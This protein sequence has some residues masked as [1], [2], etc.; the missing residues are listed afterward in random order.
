VVA[1]R[2]ATPADADGVTTLLRA[3]YGELLREHYDPAVM[4]NVLPLMT[5]ANPSLLASGTFYVV[6]LEPVGVAGCGGWTM[7]QPGTAELID[8]V[9]HIRHFATHPLA[10]RR[11]IGRT[12]MDRCRRE[13]AAQG[14]RSLQC[15]STLTAESFYAAC[16]FKTLRAMDVMIGGTVA[17]PSVVMERDL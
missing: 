11:G 14:A 1:T 9:A 6:D 4:A 16:G 8:G 5:T 10:L 17:F 12:I 7:T 13:A 3:S 15:Y 2:I